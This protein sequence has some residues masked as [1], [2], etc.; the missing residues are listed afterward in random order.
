MPIADVTRLTP[1]PDLRESYRTLGF[2]GLSE[3]VTA[4]EPIFVTDPIYLADVYNPNDDANATYLRQRAV[5][6]SDFGG[7][8]AVPVW[9]EPPFL[10][11]PT[12]WYDEQH[13]PAGATEIAEHVC[14]DSASFAFIGLNDDVPRGLRAMID[15]VERKKSGARLKLPAGTY[16]FHLEQFTPTDEH[17]QWPHLHRNVVARWTSG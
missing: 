5:I 8:T 3:L 9:W 15:E 11:I 17:K 2:S 13:M 12:S 7:D 16:R 4:G 1:I 14:C 10:V 6:V